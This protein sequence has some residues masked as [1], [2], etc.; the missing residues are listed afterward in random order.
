MA[1]SLNALP[2]EEKGAALNSGRE[3]VSQPQI[4][5]SGQTGS[6]AV[7]TPDT[8][9]GINQSRELN[10]APGD[11]P[12]SFQERS[13]FSDIP[14]ETYAELGNLTEE[15]NTGV[16]RLEAITDNT[17][18]EEEPPPEVK[19]MGFLV[20]LILLGAAMGVDLI[21]IA[22]NVFNLSGVW[23]IVATIFNILAQGAFAIITWV[24]CDKYLRDALKAVKAKKG[25]VQQQL[26]R[27]IET[28]R[29]VAKFIKPIS[30]V[31]QVADSIPLIEI[32]PM[33]MISV[34]LVYW[35]SKKIPRELLA[36]HASE[37]I[38]AGGEKMRKS[39]EAG[40]ET[41]ERG[42]EIAQ[43]IQTRMSQSPKLNRA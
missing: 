19:P 25:E 33:T 1:N 15:I 21:D 11:K 13:K 36:A 31:L 24:L 30:I 39:I 17:E 3:P 43:G 27:I 40:G 22:N 28:L 5:D 26:M 29:K 42:A 10:K 7:S 37:M 20:F 35:Y 9:Q 38:S 6:S 32:I 16:S 4:T 34:V 41:Y 2:K 18:D 14:N 12:L 8:G 23:L